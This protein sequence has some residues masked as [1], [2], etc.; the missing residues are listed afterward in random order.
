MSSDIMSRTLNVADYGLIYAG[1]QKNVGPAGAAVVIVKEELLGKTG[2]ILP[3]I[4]D[5]QSHIS[6]SSMYNTPPVFSIYVAMLN[7]RWL[8]NKGGISRS[9]AHTSELQ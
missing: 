7:L 8:K 4:F 5:Y 1:L 3:S 9:E 6:A 2:R